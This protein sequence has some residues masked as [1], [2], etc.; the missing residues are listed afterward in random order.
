M[1]KDFVPVHS[2]LPFLKDIYNVFLNLLI[3]K[4]FLEE[5]LT[6]CDLNWLENACFNAATRSVWGP[7]AGAVVDLVEKFDEIGENPINYNDLIIDC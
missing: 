4:K 3:L 7:V 5:F 1:L 2:S 6:K